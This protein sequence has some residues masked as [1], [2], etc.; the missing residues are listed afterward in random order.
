L[1]TVASDD[2]LPLTSTVNDDKAKANPVT[3]EGEPVKTEDEK[4][5]PSQQSLTSSNDESSYEFT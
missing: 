4:S 5:E 2:S 3:E 1:N